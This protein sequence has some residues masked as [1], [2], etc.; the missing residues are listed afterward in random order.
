MTKTKS[1]K[2]ALLMSGLALLLCVSMLIGSTYAWFTDSVTSTGNIIKS[3]TLDVTMEWADG[4]K[5]VPADDSTDWKDASAGAIFKSDLWEPGYTEVRHIKIANEGTLALKYQLNIVANGEVSKLADV[6]DV[7][8]LDSAQQI[9]DRTVLN[10]DNKLGTLTEVLAN[11]STTASGNLEVGENHTITLA[12]KMKDSAGNEYQNLAIGSDF[13]IQLLATQL[14]SEFD[15]FDDQYDDKADYVAKFTSGTHDLNTTLIATKAGD[16]VSATGADTEVNIRGGYYDAGSIYNNCAVWAYAGATINIYD[17]TFTADGDDQVQGSG[18]HYDLIYAGSS[19]DTTESYINIYGGMFSVEKNGWLLNEADNKGVITV[20][21]GTFVNWNPANNESEGAN[22]NFLA[23]GYAVTTETKANGDVWYTVVKNVTNF[24]DLQ[25]AM[26]NGEN[27]TV[28]GKIELLAGTIFDGNNK[29]ITGTDSSIYLLNTTGNTTIQNVTV[30]GS[31]RAV[32][33]NTK[34][35][36]VTIDN[37]VLSA[38]NYAINGTISQNNFIVKNS[39]LTSWVS[40]GDGDGDGVA[41]I[42]NCIFGSGKPDMM[43]TDPLY[44]AERLQPQTDTTVSNSEFKT[45]FAISPGKAGIT[46]TLNNCTF[47]GAAITADNFVDFFGSDPYLTTH[48]ST[49]IV[50]GDTVK[51]SN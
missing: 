14:T 40:W 38:K 29:V 47:N 50:N 5:A 10:K 12:L 8:Y 16:T 26:Q 24:D 49:F 36:E 51:L 13:S 9:T 4:T 42:D 19:N 48:T 34:D 32:V 20:Y 43:G 22:T 30:D 41:I 31:G 35:G 37:C 25:E 11:I 28:S 2:R 7:Y 33:F 17:G 1:T 21:G 15:S 46:I 3:G 45:G 44:S 6:I 23:D 39:T 27:V 18:H